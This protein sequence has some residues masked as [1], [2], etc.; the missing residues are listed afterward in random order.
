MAGNGDFTLLK[1]M[2]GSVSARSPGRPTSSMS[3]TQA[4]GFSFTAD[5]DASFSS[6]YIRGS[7]DASLTFG[8]AGDAI[9]YAG[10]V[11]ASGQVYIPVFGWEGGSLS[12]GISNGEIWV[13]VDGYTVDFRL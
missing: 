9:S 5:V 10:S 13:S 11:T 8:I 6:S 12:A 2:A 7:I 1:R 3:D 4:Q